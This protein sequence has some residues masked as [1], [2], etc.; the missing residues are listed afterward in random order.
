M[1]VLVAL[2]LRLLPV[3]L[4]ASAPF[5][6]HKCSMRR[7]HVSWLPETDRVYELTRRLKA[8]AAGDGC[9]TMLE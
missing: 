5:V 1:S 3:L 8:P 4:P 6:F 7:D 9:A 2:T